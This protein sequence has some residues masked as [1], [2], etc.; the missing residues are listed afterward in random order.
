MYL[1]TS[2]RQ[3]LS[4]PAC[5]ASF[6]NTPG[7]YRGNESFRMWLTSRMDSV[8]QSGWNLASGPGVFLTGAVW[9]AGKS[10]TNIWLSLCSAK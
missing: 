8:L 2:Y 5:S 10:Q 1:R 9:D 6:H 7:I 4:E 3:D